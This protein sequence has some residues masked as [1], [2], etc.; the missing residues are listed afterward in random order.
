MSRS[1]LNLSTMPDLVP[2]MAPD[3]LRGA[4]GVYS[5]VNWEMKFQR[6]SHSP[7]GTVS[8]SLGNLSDLQYLE[9]T[10]YFRCRPTKEES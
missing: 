6:T 8:V 1:I 2:I 5:K 3:V 9:L 4:L 10:S 7:V